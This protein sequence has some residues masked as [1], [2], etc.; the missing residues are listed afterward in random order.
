MLAVFR[1][2]DNPPV[3]NTQ[4]PAP[5]LTTRWVLAVFRAGDN[6]PVPNTQHPAPFLTTRWV[7]AVFGPGDNRQ[8]LTP[9]TEHHF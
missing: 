9:N 1:P 7:L 3:P 4:H 6:P 2:G 8:Y 5:F